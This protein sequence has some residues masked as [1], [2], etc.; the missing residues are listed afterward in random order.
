M[1]SIPKSISCLHLVLA[2]SQEPNMKKLFI[3]LALLGCAACGDDNY[4]GGLIKAKVGII[5]MDS[6]LD[7]VE[8]FQFQ[9]QGECYIGMYNVGI[10]K[11]SCGGI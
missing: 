8:F 7:D 6:H 4:S 11:V 5:K 10:V 1:G 9:Y 2:F 3:L